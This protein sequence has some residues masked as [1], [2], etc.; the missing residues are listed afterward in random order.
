MSDPIL[1]YDGVCNFCNASVR[2]VLKRE[3]APE[4]RFAAL[5]SQ[6]AQALLRPLGVAPDDLSSMLV[7]VNGTLLRESDAVL[8]VASRLRPPWSWLT[9]LSFVPRPIRDAAYRAVGARRYRWW[10]RSAVCVPMA[11]AARTPSLNHR[12]LTDAP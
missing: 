6:S 1:F 3:R 12:F 4:F 7:L 9:L 10:G 11:H 2:F 8:Y 5:Q